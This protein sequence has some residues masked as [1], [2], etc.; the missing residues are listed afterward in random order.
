M[1]IYGY[2][3]NNPFFLGK[4]IQIQN[5]LLAVLDQTIRPRQGGAHLLAELRLLKQFIPRMTEPIGA[6]PAS[7]LLT[8]AC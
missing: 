2:C 7:D 5:V 3:S 8:V 6:W 1:D 4:A